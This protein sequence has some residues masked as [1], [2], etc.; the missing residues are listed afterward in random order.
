M[1]KRGVGHVIL[2]K[3]DNVELEYNS[4]FKLILNSA[5]VFQLR[6][7]IHIEKAYCVN[8]KEHRY[9]QYSEVLD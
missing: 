8:W 6:Q 2:I 5:L 9:F 3:R 4:T 1:L 7:Y